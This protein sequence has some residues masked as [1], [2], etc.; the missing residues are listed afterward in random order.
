MELRKTAGE[1][2]REAVMIDLHIDTLMPTAYS[3]MMLFYGI[4]E[5]AV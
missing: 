1:L 4:V 3:G 5:D 2:I